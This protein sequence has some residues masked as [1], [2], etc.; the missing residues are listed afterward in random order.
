M[1]EFELQRAARSPRVLRSPSPPPS[2]LIQVMTVETWHE[3]YRE[4]A[5]ESPLNQ[6]THRNAEEFFQLQHVMPTT[7]PYIMCA[8]DPNYDVRMPRPVLKERFIAIAAELQCVK[9][10]YA[11]CRGLRYFGDENAGAFSPA[12]GG[13][14][15]YIHLHFYSRA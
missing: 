6:F 15:M 4:K 14:G 12:K 13:E 7:L 8:L 3:Y 11:T 5:R 2:A 1:Q 9:R 10:M